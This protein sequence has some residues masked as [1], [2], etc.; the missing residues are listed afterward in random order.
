MDKKIKTIIKMEKDCY[1]RSIKF[2]DVGSPSV[3]VLLLLNKR[4]KKL[5]WH[6]IGQ[7]REQS[8]KTKL[9][10]GRKKDRVN[11]K[12]WSR[13]RRKMQE[14]NQNLTGRTQG[15]WQNIK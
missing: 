11:E 1:C 14:V 4:I 9:N 12:P 15:S 2:Y 8:E 3:Y 7:N 13:Q 5:L 6:V 10:V